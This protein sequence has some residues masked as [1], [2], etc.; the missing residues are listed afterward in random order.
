M[1]ADNELKFCT[2]ILYGIK[3]RFRQKNYFFIKMEIE[4]YNTELT[5]CQDRG[6]VTLKKKVFSPVTKKKHCFY[7]VGN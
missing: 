4:R 5:H 7:F 3:S 2:M 6:R 1:T